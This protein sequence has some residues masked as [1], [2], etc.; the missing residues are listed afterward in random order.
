MGQH[1]YSGKSIHLK[2]RYFVVVCFFPNELMIGIFTR[3]C[4]ASVVLAIALCLSVCLSV[5]VSVRHKSV[6]S[7]RLNE[8]SFVAQRQPSNYPALCWKVIWVYPKISVL[9]SG[10]LS[11]N[12]DLENFSI[13]R[14][15]SQ[16]LSTWVN[17]QCD[18][19]ATVVGRQFI[20][21]SVHLCV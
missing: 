19:L 13:A 10:T 16:V 14:R 3:R 8:S 15:Q 1:G 4:C 11:K 9:P 7:K 18:K 21:L 5:C 12:P 17:A 2:R 20:P 6:L